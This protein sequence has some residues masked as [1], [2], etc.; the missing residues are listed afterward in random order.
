MVQAEKTFQK[1]RKMDFEALIAKGENPNG[2]T[3]QTANGTAK[4]GRVEPGWNRQWDEPYTTPQVPATGAW[5]GNRT[6]E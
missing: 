5:S 3:A 6:G 4:G 1:L 2:M